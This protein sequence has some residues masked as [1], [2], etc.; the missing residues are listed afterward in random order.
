MFDQLIER[1]LYQRDTAFFSIKEKVFLLRELSY[2]IEGWV[3]IAEAVNIIQTSSE[4]WSVKKICE[5]MAESLNKGE[6]LSRAMRRLPKY[7]NEGDCNIIKSGEGSG[8]L[9]HV[10]KYLAQEY[11]FLHMIKNKYTSAMIYPAFLFLVSLGAIYILFTSVLPGIFD[12]VEQ[13]NIT[14][15]PPTTKRL[16]AITSFV[17]VHVN[18]IILG[19]IL[20]VFWCSVMFSTEDGRRSLQLFSFRLPV[21]GTLTRYYILIKCLRYMKLLMYSGMNY[22]D[23]FTYLRDI[24]QNTA[25]KDPLDAVIV[26]IQLWWTIGGAL[27]S[28][29]SFIPKDVIALIKVGEETAALEKSL[30]NAVLMYEDEFQ[31]LL[32]GVSKIIE[33]V[34]IVFVG[35]IIAATAISVFGIIGSML[36]SLQA[37]G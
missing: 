9:T 5:A 34:L 36:E 19:I 3:A 10:L 28:Y 20:I 35:S 4:K 23:V 15:I 24:M 31:K 27:E 18:Q 26:R 33:P 37:G 16:M 21:V 17:S 14:S 25:Y 32:D 7:F 13:F 11:E 22:L 12:M 29:T 6:A 1:F 30:E 8:E 2:L